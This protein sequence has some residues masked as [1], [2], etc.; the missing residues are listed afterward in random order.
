MTDMIQNVTTGITSFSGGAGLTWILAIVIFA[1]TILTVF[2]V[3]KNFRKFIYGGITTGILI[4][5]GFFSKAVANE[6]VLEHNYN[7]IKWVVGIIL[8]VGVS[9]LVGFIVQKTSAVKKFEDSFKED[10][11][12]KI[13]EKEK[14][15]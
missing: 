14:K 6:T 9:I 7:P 12:D 1:G 2:F 5:V 11:T 3:S 13:M 15:K 4:G 8:F 10:V